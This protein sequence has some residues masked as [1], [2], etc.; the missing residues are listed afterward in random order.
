MDPIFTTKVIR[1]WECAV[2]HAV[3]SSYESASVCCDPKYEC[4]WCYAVILNVKPRKE[5][6]GM[7]LCDECFKMMIANNMTP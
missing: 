1:S 2:C 3:H 4:E 6:E 7:Y 5:Y